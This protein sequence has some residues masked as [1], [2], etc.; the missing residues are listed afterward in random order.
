MLSKPSICI[1]LF[2]QG[3]DYHYPI[4]QMRKLSLL[5]VTWLV[6]SK[7]GTGFQA[8]CLLFSTAWQF[9]ELLEG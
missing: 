3:E 9:H 8:A 6:S 1:N 4:L 5:K 7:A 2:D